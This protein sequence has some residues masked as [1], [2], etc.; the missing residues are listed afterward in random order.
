MSCVAAV[1][2]SPCSL[3][4]LTYWNILSPTETASSARTIFFRAVWGGRIVSEFALTTRINATRTAVGDDGDQQ[5]L[6]R[7]MPRKGIR[8]VGV[9]RE[10]AKPPTKFLRLPR[11]LMR[12]RQNEQRRAG[13]QQNPRN[14]ASSRSRHASYCSAPRTPGWTRRIYAT[15]SE[16][17]IAASLK[18]LVGTTDSS[19]TRT[20]T[21]RLLYFGYPEAHEDDPE[22]AVR[23][24]LELVAAVAALNDPTRLQTRVG[25]ATGLVV[26]GDMSDAGGAQQ[27]GIIGE[28]LTIAAHLQALAEPDTAVIAG[29]TRKLLGNLFDLQDLGTKDLKGV[30]GPVRA[31]AALRPSLAASR[32]EALHGVGLTDLVG[33]EEELELLLR[34]WSRAKPGEGQVV[35]LS[36]EPGIGKSRLCAAL[37]ETIATE[38]HTRLRN[39]CS[40]QHADSALYPTIGQVE[41]AAGFTRDDT[42]REKLDKLDDCSHKA[43]LRLTMQRFSRRCYRCPTM[44]VTRRSNLHRNSAGN[45]HS[46]LWFCK[47]RPYRGK[48]RC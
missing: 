19:R 41:R 15:L 46:K 35:M 40:R 27:R 22:H 5:R 34:R 4:S 12:K 3:R 39:F 48:T 24:A 16:A 2:R 26:V 13:I 7:T 18:W 9:V 44:V 33:R 32:F 8:F 23:A 10:R 28:T 45:E 36:G 31:W 37:L 25:I 6:I 20:G 42:V 38:P 11:S 43:R 30:G 14:V 21:L 29:S 1:S 17:I 47:S